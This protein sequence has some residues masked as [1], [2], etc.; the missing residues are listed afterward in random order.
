MAALAAT[1][2]EEKCKQGNPGGGREVSHC[3]PTREGNPGW[4]RF[5]AG[6][7][8]LLFRFRVSNCSGEGSGC[9]PV[10]NPA[11]QATHPTPHSPPH[12]RTPGAL[13]EVEAGEVGVPSGMDEVWQSFKDRGGFRGPRPT[14]SSEAAL[15]VPAQ[16]RDCRARCRLCTKAR[17]LLGPQFPTVQVAQCG[18]LRPTPASDRAE[19]VAPRLPTPDSRLPRRQVICS[20]S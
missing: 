12:L 9:F 17:P 14:A 16:P 4:G 5:P 13:G 10:G 20:A 7:S 2:P 19:T 15:R 3:G 11:A 8:C 1:W 6:A 18:P